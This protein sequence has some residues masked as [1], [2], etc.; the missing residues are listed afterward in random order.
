MLPV[1]YCL[2]N[3]VRSVALTSSLNVGV[4]D[5][6]MGFSRRSL[7]RQESALLLLSRLG[8]GGVTIRRSDWTLWGYGKTRHSLTD[9]NGN[10]IET[11]MAVVLPGMHF[12]HGKRGLQP[13]VWDLMVSMW[14]PVLVLAA[15]PAISVL[16]WLRGGAPTELGAGNG[17]L[18]SQFPGKPSYVSAIA[19]QI[20]EVHQDPLRVIQA[21][22]HNSP[23]RKRLLAQARRIIGGLPFFSRERSEHEKH[24][25]D[26]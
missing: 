25:H 11:E 12:A 14:Y 19:P 9:T 21:R 1:S 7:Q 4:V 5:G 18:G 16:R 26:A 10:F 2:P 20:R 24:N 17:K 23:Y 6:T 22:G 15:L 13:A 8:P 3:Q